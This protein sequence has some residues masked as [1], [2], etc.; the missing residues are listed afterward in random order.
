MYLSARRVASQPLGPIAPKPAPTVWLRERALRR[1]G[2]L[3]IGHVTCRVRC[4]V[5][6]TFS[7]AEGTRRST[8]D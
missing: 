7:R 2:W 4:N 1:G 8:G 3:R 5:T 6:V